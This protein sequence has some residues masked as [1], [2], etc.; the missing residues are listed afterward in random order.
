MPRIATTTPDLSRHQS[1]GGWVLYDGECPLCTK[2]AT[3]FSSLLQRHHFE[4]APLQAPWVQR[5]LELKPGEPLVEMK[6]LAADGRVF[7]GA[8]ALLEIARRIWWAWPLFALAQ[9]PGAT[10]LAGWVYRRI[11]ANRHCLGGACTVKKRGR[12]HG[13][14]SFFE[15]P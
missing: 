3:R 6:F 11:A 5:R 15:M 9:I 2:A 10:P 14:T 4:L 8:V 13:V 1:A 12:H 7:G